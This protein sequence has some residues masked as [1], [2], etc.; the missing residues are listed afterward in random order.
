MNP[1]LRTEAD[2]QAI[3][4]GVKDGTLDCVG[5]DHAPHTDY[6][7][8]QEFDY[9]PFGIVGLETALPITLEV[10]HREAGM[11]L[12]DTISVLTDKAAG[13]LHLDAGNLKEGANADITIFDPDETWTV[14]PE[15]FLSK[16]ANSPWVDCEMKG[17]V[18][19]TIVGG[20]LVY[21]GA[22][23]VC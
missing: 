14:D 2:R 10:L 5:T 16:S 17:R 19:S 13:V 23:I 9:A 20:K 7:K 6:E 11:S 3:I 4:E 8:D 15:K 22:K 1:P 12:S 21:D 18:K